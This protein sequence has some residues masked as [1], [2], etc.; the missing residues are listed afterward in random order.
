MTSASPNMIRRDASPTACVPVAQAVTTE[1][2]GPRS[3]ADGDLARSQ[4]GQRARDEEG[5]TRRGPLSR[6]SMAVS[7]MRADARRCPS[8]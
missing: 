3:R 4:V 7:A 1:W 6:S 2:L 8:R 5:L